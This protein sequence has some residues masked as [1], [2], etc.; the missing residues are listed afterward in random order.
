MFTIT[1]YNEKELDENQALFYNSNFM[2]TKF[3]GGLKGEYG[4]KPLYLIIENSVVKEMLVVLIRP[5]VS[6]FSIAY[7]PHGPSE[8][9]ICDIE[10]KVLSKKIK[11]FLPKK[12][13]LIRYDLLLNK[14]ENFKLHGLK[15]SSVDIQV[16][17]TTILNIAPEEDD[18]LKGMHKKTRYN[19]KLAT[20]K[21]VEIKEVDISEL[22]RW[23]DMY[24][25]TAKRDAIAIHSKAYYKSVYNRAK[26]SNTTD[27]KLLFAEHEGELLA[28]IFVLIC[29]NKATYLYG[30]S[31]NNKRNLMPA[32]LLQ[33]KAIQL[34]K[35]AGAEKY[36][37]FGIP[38][39]GDKGHSMQGLYSFKT[40]FG[41]DIINR[42]GCFDY[43]LTYLSIAFRNAEIL[44]NFYYKKLRKVK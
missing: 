9:L 11:P 32:Y 1:A 35:A 40:R 3:W 30:A 10:L 24:M 41:G 2:Q 26:E 15:K 8:A 20:K 43:S 34:S 33:W 4:F 42:V 44:R 5:V 19:I 27:M 38:P 37:F 29:G 13:M 17:D 6:G 14:T 16:P 23:Y 31:S 39:T 25:V 21:G 36:D 18:I 7:I 28:G 12:C 22:D